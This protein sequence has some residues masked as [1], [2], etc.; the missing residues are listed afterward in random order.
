MIFVTVGKMP[1]GFER[2]VRAADE[3][4]AQ[5]GEE[6]FIQTGSC[7]YRPA[8]AAFRDFL[9]FPEAQEQLRR[10]D[11]VIAHAGIG[12]IIAAL[13]AA[14]PLVI[15]PRR[16]R[17]REHYNDHQQEVAEALQGRPG[18]AVIRE[19]GELPAAVAAVRGWRGA[20]QAGATAPG[21]FRAIEEFLGSAV[22]K[23]RR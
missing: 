17:D 8:H 7:G 14:R 6:V 3:L 2:L 9:T 15:M 5:L 12:T 11:L 1:L 21:L 18:I 20:P 19:A 23:E 22:R 16:R 10:A 13:Q 4:A